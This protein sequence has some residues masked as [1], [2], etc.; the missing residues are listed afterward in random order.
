MDSKYNL[1]RITGI[2]RLTIIL[3]FTSTIILFAQDKSDHA[4]GRQDTEYDLPQI[5]I[6]NYLLGAQSDNEGLKVSCIFFLGKYRVLEANSQ[7]IEE[8]GNTEDLNLKVLIAWSIYMIGEE[9]GLDKLE[10]LAL[11]NESLDLKSFCSNLHGIKTL[12]NALNQGYVR[13][14]DSRVYTD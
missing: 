5:A 8:I 12:E 3:L 9:S 13:L 10:E 2:F 14:P 6:K 11:S 1:Y 4:Y 7:L